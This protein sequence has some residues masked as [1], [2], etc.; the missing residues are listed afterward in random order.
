MSFNY[1]IYNLAIKTLGSSEK[2][3]HWFNT[4]NKAL[5]GFPPK[6]FL[7]SKEGQDQLSNLLHRISYGIIS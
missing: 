1:N 2:A 6:D 3:D 5:G 4:P 7:S